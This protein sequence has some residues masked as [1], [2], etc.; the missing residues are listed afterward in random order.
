MRALIAGWGSGK[1]S[2]PRSQAGTHEVAPV[3][4]DQ[5]PLP[6]ALTSTVGR[7]ILLH[8]SI[9]R[10]AGRPKSSKVT[11][12]ETGLP[13]K[14]STRSLAN[15]TECQRLTRAHAH[16]PEIDAATLGEGTCLSPG[17]S[18]PTETPAEVTESSSG[19]RSLVEQA[20]NIVDPVTGYSR[21]RAVAPARSTTAARYGPLLS[22]IWPGPGV[23]R[24][25]V[26]ARPPSKRWPL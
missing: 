22:R 14:P 19:A 12:A 10:R 8:R 5:N 24:P 17:S 6:P 3:G 23:A 16:T 13:G 15:H 9:L 2:I 4:F 18:S 7:S 11:A 21:R 26:P 25:E 20:A 1:S